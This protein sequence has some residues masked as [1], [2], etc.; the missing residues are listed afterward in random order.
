MRYTNSPIAF[1]GSY[2][3]SWA[4]KKVDDYLYYPKY[5]SRH[6]INFSLEYSLGTGWVASSVWSYSSGLPFTQLNGYYDKIYLTNIFNPW[7]ESGNL[8]PYLILGDQ[9]LGRLPAYH[10]LDLSISKT[11]ELIGLKTEIDFSIVNVYNRKNIFYF[12]RDT[13]EQ[14]NMLPF[15]LTATFRIEI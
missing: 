11:T 7:Y 9:N 4:Y 15:L 13:G 14:V 6:A 10:R 1:T 3:L 5:D 2:A 12:E 8:N